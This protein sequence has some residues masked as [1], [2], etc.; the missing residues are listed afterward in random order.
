MGTSP[1]WRY[2]QGLPALAQGLDRRRA[3]GFPI[4]LKP[5][6]AITRW[7]AASSP[8]SPGSGTCDTESG[9]AEHYHLG[10]RRGLTTVP[11]IGSKQ[12][13]AASGALR[14][15]RDEAGS[16]RDRHANTRQQPDPDLLVAAV[17]AAGAGDLRTAD[18]GRRTTSRFCGKNKQLTFKPRATVDLCSQRSPPAFAAV[19]LGA[20]RERGWR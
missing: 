13:P 2:R 5:P 11:S 17:K 9:F 19:P 10:G 3:R 6:A 15:L 4:C 14:R 16:G 18:Q 20:A 7:R 8:P 1:T 12:L